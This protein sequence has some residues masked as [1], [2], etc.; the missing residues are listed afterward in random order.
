[1]GS[2]NVPIYASSGRRWREIFTL[3]K[4]QLDLKG[5]AILPNSGSRTKHTWYSFFNEECRRELEDTSPGG[6]L[7]GLSIYANE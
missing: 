7:R 4:D 2:C 5:R 1:M 6:R 3:K